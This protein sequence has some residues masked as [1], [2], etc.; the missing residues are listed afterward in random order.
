M[1]PDHALRQSSLNGLPRDNQ[2]KN[3]VAS[4]KNVP[5]IP[6][7]CLMQFAPRYFRYDARRGKTERESFSFRK[8]PL[9]WSTV[10][11]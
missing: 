11:V 1:T 2:D 10:K 8:A 9:G 5:R 3:R 4:S 6:S 7:C